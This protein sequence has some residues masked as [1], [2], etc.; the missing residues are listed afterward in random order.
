VNN[1]TILLEKLVALLLESSCFFSVLV[2]LTITGMGKKQPLEIIEDGQ[3]NNTQCEI[4]ATIFHGKPEETSVLAS[5]YKEVNRH[6]LE[7]ILHV[8]V[9]DVRALEFNRERCSGHRHLGKGFRAASF[10]GRFF[11]SIVSASLTTS[12]SLST[13]SSEKSESSSSSASRSA[14]S[15]SSVSVV[16]NFSW[17]DDLHHI[18]TVNTM[19]FTALKN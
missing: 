13:A 15:F 2:E 9:H 19:E 8:V 6:T 10:A 1:H 4:A 3:E 17:Q 12:S 7:S 18:G 16:A 14:L 5:W 11:P